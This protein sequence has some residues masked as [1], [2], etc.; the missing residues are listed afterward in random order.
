MPE[1]TPDLAIVEEVLTD[2]Q[3]VWGRFGSGLAELERITLSLADAKAGRDVTI[4]NFE[5]LLYREE[6]GTKSVDKG[7]GVVSF[8]LHSAQAFYHSDSGVVAMQVNGGSLDI[9]FELNRFATELNLNH[10]A[11]GAIDFIA[12]GN[13]F[14]GG[15]FHSQD[16]N[17][18]IAGAV[19]ID[20]SEAGYFFERQLQEGAIKGLTLWNSQ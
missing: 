3:L 6:N 20:G 18:R 1:F 19:S 8:A 14:N 15:F 17:Q 12:A 13:L 10:S 5:Y 16:A 2:R 11:T 9:D 7:L 4:G